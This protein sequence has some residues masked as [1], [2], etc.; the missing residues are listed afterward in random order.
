M[1]NLWDRQLATP[2]FT[3]VLDLNPLAGHVHQHHKEPHLEHLEG[4]EDLGADLH[5]GGI[6]RNHL[7]IEGEDIEDPNIHPREG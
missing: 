5:R 3:L 6:T 1:C 7:G 4:A 2:I